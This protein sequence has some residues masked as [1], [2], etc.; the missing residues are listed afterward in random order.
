MSDRTAL[1]RHWDADGNL[2]YVGISL[3]AVGR[4]NQHRRDSH[5]SD[6]IAS[7]TIEYFASREM[8]LKA[9][10]DAIRSESPEHN[11]AGTCGHGAPVAGGH[12]DYMSPGRSSRR[13]MPSSL[14]DDLVGRALWK[15]EFYGATWSNVISDCHQEAMWN[16][17]RY[18]L[19]NQ[20]ISASLQRYL[21]S[22][23]YLEDGDRYYPAACG[24]YV[25]VSRLGP[26]AN[27]NSTAE[28]KAA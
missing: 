22:G 26:L 21:Y 12:R 9:E 20:D 18:R 8:A 28:N 1:Y 15:G 25:H 4:L 24:N 27:D 11:I 3:S 7:V 16:Y 5:W 14:I 2:L 23:E 6:E 10:A 13:Q 19:T 17:R